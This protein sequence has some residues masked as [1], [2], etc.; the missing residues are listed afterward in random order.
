MLTFKHEGESVHRPM[1]FKEFADIY[2][3]KRAEVMSFAKKMSFK[4]KISKIG[5]NVLSSLLNY[6]WTRHQQQQKAPV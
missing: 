4:T 2:N 6:S 5:S 1:K 3:V